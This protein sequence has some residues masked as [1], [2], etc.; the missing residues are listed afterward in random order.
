MPSLKCISYMAE[1]CNITEH[2]VQ[3]HAHPGY[4]VLPIEMI[5]HTQTLYVM[6]QRVNVTSCKDGT[7][8][9]ILAT[10]FSS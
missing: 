6:P 5:Q 10:I 4:I 7:Y 9:M 3:L 8:A 1:W 2:Y